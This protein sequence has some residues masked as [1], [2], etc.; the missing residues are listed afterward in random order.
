MFLIDLESV[1]G[2]H[3]GE[4]GE[5]KKVDPKQPVKVCRDDGE[6]RRRKP[7]DGEAANVQRICERWQRGRSSTC[8]GSDSAARPEFIVSRV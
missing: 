4:G 3:I 1:H 2:T 8:K 5:Q 6:R 7:G